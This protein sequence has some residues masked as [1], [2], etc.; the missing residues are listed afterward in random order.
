[1][2]YSSVAQGEQID[3]IKRGRRHDFYEMKGDR[4]RRDLLLERFQTLR[5]SIKVDNLD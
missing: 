3:F 2:H 1:M 5:Q 4:E